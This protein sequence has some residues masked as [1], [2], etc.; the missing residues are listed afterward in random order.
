MKARNRCHGK[1]LVKQ[2][3]DVWV[4][5]LCC[6]QKM[7]ANQGV[8]TAKAVQTLY[9]MVFHMPYVTTTGPRGVCLRCP[10]V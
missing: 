7:P 9:M 4:L 8:L 5:L 3:A 2:F 6:V 1:L 10:N